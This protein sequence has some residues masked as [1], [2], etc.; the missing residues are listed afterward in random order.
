MRINIKNIILILVMIFCGDAFAQ[1]PQ[2]EQL[3]ASIPSEFELGA[4]LSRNGNTFTEF[5]KKGQSVQDWSDMI[6]VQI[7]QGLTISPAQFLQRLGGD[8]ISACPGTISRHNIING[9]IN[10]YPVS[11]LDLWCPANPQTK[12]PESI[13]IRVIKGDGRLYSVQ[14]AWR[15]V[16]SN[17]QVITA[18]NFLKSVTACD[19]RTTAHPCPQL[20]SN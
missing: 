9:D 13:F 19:N 1:I 8:I 6:T 14:Y 5:I 7:F 15:S 17:E 4:D 2:A 12:K 16:P 3:L 11:M 20:S 10:G 18:V